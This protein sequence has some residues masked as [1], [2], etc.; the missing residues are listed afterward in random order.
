[1][2][3]NMVMSIVKEALYTSLLVG[4]PILILSLVVGLLVSI[5]Q[6]TTQIQEQTLTFVPKLIVIAITLV[7]GGNWMLQEIVKFTNKIM[8]MIAFIKG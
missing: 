1:M 6:A 7:V 4:G 5:F 3:E 2:T 8:T